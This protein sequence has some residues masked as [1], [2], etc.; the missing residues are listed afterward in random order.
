MTFLTISN[1]SCGFFSLF[2]F[3]ISTMRATS[4]RECL[5]SAILLL[6]VVCTKDPQEAYPNP[7]GLEASLQYPFLAVLYRPS[8]SLLASFIGNEKI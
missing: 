4:T 6:P 1:P 2:P 8:L 7:C 3:T 5:M